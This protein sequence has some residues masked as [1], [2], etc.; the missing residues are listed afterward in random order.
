LGE[1]SI[2]RKSLSLW[3]QCD[4]GILQALKRNHPEIRLVATW[5]PYID[6]VDS[7][8]RWRNL[9]TQRLPNGSIPGLPAGYGSPKAQLAWVKAHD[10]F[11][12]TIFANDP[13]FLRLDVTAPDAQEKLANHIGRPIPWWGRANVGRQRPK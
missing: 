9:G 2:L 3:P 11:L 1:V 7:M 13:A 12:Q 10:H 6:I 8:A 4:F 5:R